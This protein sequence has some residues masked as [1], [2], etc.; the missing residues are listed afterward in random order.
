MTNR[1]LGRCDACHRALEKNERLFKRDGDTF[2]LLICR[3][4]LDLR[5]RRTFSCVCCSG[6]AT[7]AD[8]TPDGPI[9]H[10]CLASSQR[11]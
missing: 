7:T 5:K 8:L 10:A 1:L 6:P 3:H 4:C 2:D 9:C 11:R